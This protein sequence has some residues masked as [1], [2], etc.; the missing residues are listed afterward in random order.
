[1]AGVIVALM[2]LAAPAAA[3][4]PKLVADPTHGPGGTAVAVSGSGFCATCGVVEIDFGSTPV[5]RGLVVAANGSFQTTI[6]VPGGAQAG[7]N[8]INAYQEAVLVTQTPFEVTP[9]TAAPTGNPSSTPPPRSTPA[10]SHSPPGTPPASGTPQGSP[11]TTVGSGS[12]SPVAAGAQDTFP[13]G[14]L[15]LI[16]VVLAVAAG[17]ITVVAWRRRGM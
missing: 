15:V 1:V 13:V 14:L 2:T 9:S 3:A 17:A 4:T 16:V 5:K 11:V 6:T 8:A 7:T 10:S 12:P